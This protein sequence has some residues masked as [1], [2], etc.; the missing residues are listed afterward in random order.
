L[1]IA[2]VGKHRGTVLL[3][4]VD[5]A[6]GV[7]TGAVYGA[8]PRGPVGV[9]AWTTPSRYRVRLRPRSSTIEHW[10]VRVPA[11][12]A[13]G[14]HLGCIVAEDAH[15]STSTRSHRG[16]RFKIDVRGQTIIAVEIRVQSRAAP[17]T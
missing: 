17:S 3:S 2:N 13:A 5:A 1:R 9:G 14:D 4:A 8:S 7:T 11:G 6:T 12:T 15:G 10:T 16:R